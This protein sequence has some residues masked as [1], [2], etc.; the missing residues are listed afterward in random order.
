MKKQ[1]SKP[2]TNKAGG[3]RELTLQDFRQAIDF[4]AL[5]QSVRQ[6]IQAIKKVGR[7][8][9]ETPKEM[10][11]FRFAPEVLAGIRGLGKGYNARVE[12]VLRNALEHGS[13]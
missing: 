12:S 3:V 10:I 9:S 8:R 13:I 6:K 2:L 7:P 11:A 4:D 5:P 1:K